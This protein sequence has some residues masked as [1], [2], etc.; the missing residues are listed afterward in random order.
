[1]KEPWKAVT[2]AAGGDVPGL[3]VLIRQ[4]AA[5]AMQVA[6]AGTEPQVAEA[7]KVLGDARRA[8]YRILAEEAPA[9]DE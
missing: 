5:A 1:V 6:Q 9:D 4:L 8:L 7:R 3:L 2:D